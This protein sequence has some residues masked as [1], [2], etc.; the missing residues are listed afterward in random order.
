MTDQRVANLFYRGLGSKYFRLVGQTV[1][2]IIIQ[3][4]LWRNATKVYYLD[5]FV[6]VTNA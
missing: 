2:V 1:S 3:F 6:A 4:C 5:F